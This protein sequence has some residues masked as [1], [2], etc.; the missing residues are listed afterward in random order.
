MIAGSIIYFGAKTLINKYTTNKHNNIVNSVVLIEEPKQINNT[1]T[2]I[3]IKINK[4]DKNG[5]ENGGNW[6][7]R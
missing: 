2:T 4:I 7:S 5:L 6:H 1:I 3:P